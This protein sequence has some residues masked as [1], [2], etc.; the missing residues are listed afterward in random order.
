MIYDVSNACLGLLNGMVQV[1]NMIELGQIRAGLVVGTECGRE[2]V[3]NT[4]AQLN[5]DLPRIADVV[6]GCRAPEVMRVAMI[7]PVLAAAE[8]VELGRSDAAAIAEAIVAWRLPSALP[9]DAADRLWSWWNAWLD[10][11]AKWPVAVAALDELL[12]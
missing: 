11:A 7:P 9:A 3:E 6:R 4:I 12:A 5:S 10:G 1:A 2:L 8:T